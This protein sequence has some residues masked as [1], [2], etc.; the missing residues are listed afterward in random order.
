MSRAPR[1]IPE[2]EKQTPRET[3]EPNN[4]SQQAT[5]N[6]DNQPLPFFLQ[7]ATGLVTPAELSL[8][9]NFQTSVTH[10]QRSLIRSI[11]YL[12][13]I[14]ERKVYKALGFCSITDYAASVA[15]FS[16]NQTET[17]LALGRKLEG[18]PGVRK[19]LSNGSLSWSKARIIVDRAE[20]EDEGKWL[21]QS[22]GLSVS[23]L[24][25]RLEQA[26]PI[27]KTPQGPLSRSFSKASSS[28]DSVDQFRV[29]GGVRLP[30]KRESL[31]GVGN[32]EPLRAPER[33]YVGYSF[34]P[35]QYSRWA[36]LCERLRKQGRRESKEELALLGLG[37]LAFGKEDRGVGSSS[38]PF[39]LHLVECPTCKQVTLTNNRGTFETPRPLIEAAHC[40]SMIQAK[41][42]SRRASIPPRVRRLVLERDGNCCQVPGCRNTIYLELHH[43]QAAAA[44]GR[45]IPKNLT[46]LCST[47]HRALHLREIQLRE[48][49]RDPL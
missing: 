27:H 36:D 33:C 48:A 12:R 16:R 3:P 26:L 25:K 2:S 41:D 32:Q 49:A 5:K 15:G 9:K 30:R 24:R 40:D 44:G 1:E 22:R 47:C 11:H 21:D 31:P 7:S 17:F 28:E 20:P 46:T 38:V 19:S 34:L 13:V 23:E 10:L 42:G 37:A 14:F 35:E 18:F 39:V 43:R 8:H 4:P 29:A 45:S 6:P